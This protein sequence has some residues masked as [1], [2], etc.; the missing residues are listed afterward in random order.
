MTAFGKRLD[1][2]GGRRHSARAPVLMSAA[3]HAV[4]TSQ[5]V[6]LVDVSRTGAKLRGHARWKS[7][8]RSG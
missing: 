4:G 8:R 2:P 1:G 7:A 3:M 6:S 5:T